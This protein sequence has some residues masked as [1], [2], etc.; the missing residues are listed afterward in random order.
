M[1]IILLQITGNI[2]EFK[3]AV[4]LVLEYVSFDN[5]NVVQVFEATIRYNLVNSIF[6]IKIYFFNIFKNILFSTKNIK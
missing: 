6:E 4:K 1:C 3:N 2:S 5:D